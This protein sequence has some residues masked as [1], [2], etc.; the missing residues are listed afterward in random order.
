MYDFTI[1]LEFDLE[2]IKFEVGFSLE[3]TR[4]FFQGN[5]IATSSSKL[6]T[7]IDLPYRPS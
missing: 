7:T 2:P 6:R 1:L 3:D 4:L 5:L